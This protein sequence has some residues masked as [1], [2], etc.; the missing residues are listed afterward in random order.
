MSVYVPA[1]G[2]SLCLPIYGRMPSV[3]SLL[4]PVWS[5]SVTK[6]QFPLLFSACPYLISL[7]YVQTDGR[8]P[9]IKCISKSCMYS[10]GAEVTVASSL[11]SKQVLVLNIRC[12]MSVKENKES[13][14][15]HG[16]N[17][18]EKYWNRGG[19]S[20]SALKLECR[21]CLWWGGGIY[22]YTLMLSKPSSW[23]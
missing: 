7:R 10:K 17:G 5:V 13:C 18:W 19:P 2:M 23:T 1:P 8:L 4:S 22:D 9:D 20:V 12:K 11:S 14:R 21:I 15:S 6:N 16:E 3:C